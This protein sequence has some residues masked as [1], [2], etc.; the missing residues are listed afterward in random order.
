[1]RAATL[2]LQVEKTPSPFYITVSPLSTGR[3]QYWLRMLG[4][5]SISLLSVACT[6][7]SFLLCPCSIPAFRAAVISNIV[8]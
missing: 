8:K 1:M 7:I 5:V 2:G 6:C 4:T 3:A